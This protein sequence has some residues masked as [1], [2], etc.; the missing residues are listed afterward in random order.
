M[1]NNQSTVATLG[2]PNMTTAPQTVQEYEDVIANL[3]NQLRETEF[4][5]RQDQ[6]RLADLQTGQEIEQQMTR[7]VDAQFKASWK[8]RTEARIKTLCALNRA[9]NALCAW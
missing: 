8:G 3:R 6:A 9:G 5:R 1:S 2:S 7:D 4:L